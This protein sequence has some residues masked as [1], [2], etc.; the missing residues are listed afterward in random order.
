MT[1]RDGRDDGAR[2]EVVGARDMVVGARER[3]GVPRRV[4]AA[5]G[6]GRRAVDGFGGGLKIGALEGA[7]KFGGIRAAGDSSSFCLMFGARGGS[8]KTL[9]DLSA[10]CNR[11]AGFA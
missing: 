2:V 10:A 9:S 8:I 3:G 11:G 6:G 7:F 4:D 1:F 5:E